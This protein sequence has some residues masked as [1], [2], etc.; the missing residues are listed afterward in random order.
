[1]KVVVIHT[2][3]I[4]CELLILQFCLYQVFRKE[5][6][7]R[8]VITTSVALSEPLPINGMPCLH[9]L[10][11]LNRRVW[12]DRGVDKSTGSFFRAMSSMFHTKSWPW[13]TG[14]GGLE[15]FKLES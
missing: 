2:Q 4:S 14:S 5:H 7:F 9:R 8:Y 11:R 15:Q 12:N 6:L 1:M 13:S 3:A 10:N